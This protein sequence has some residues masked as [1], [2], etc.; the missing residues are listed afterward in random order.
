M[1]MRRNRRDRVSLADVLD[2]FRAQGKDYQT[3]INA[4]LRKYYEAKAG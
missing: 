3:M 1:P 2:W 4:V